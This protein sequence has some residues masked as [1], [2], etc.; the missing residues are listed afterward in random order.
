[1][2]RWL[3]SL[4]TTT[5]LGWVLAGAAFAGGGPGNQPPRPLEW[6]WKAD[7]ARELKKM[8]ATAI[9]E[10]EGSFYLETPH[11]RVRTWHTPL[12]TAQAALYMEKFFAVFS[13]AFLLKRGPA[14]PDYKP[15][16]CVHASRDDYLKASKGPEWSA[17]VC[18]P[19]TN[20]DGSPNI[21][22]HVY[23][24]PPAG[25]GR[26]EA[27]FNASVPL[28]VIQHEG[29][30]CL[31]HRLFGARP[32][33]YW[34]DEGAANY[35]GAWCLRWRQSE[36]GETWNDS[37]HRADRMLFSLWP[38][39]LRSYYQNH[40]EAPL[41]R[42]RE[43]SAANSMKE[44]YVDGGGELTRLNYAL[45]ESFI[46]F[47]MTSKKR[48]P[49]FLQILERVRALP[50]DQ[51]ESP[52]PLVTDEEARAHEEQW[53]LFLINHWGVK[54]ADAPIKARAAELRRKK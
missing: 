5:A 44:F 48:R 24:A 6:Q 53:L 21:S 28:S 3:F 15:L 4:L 14:Y 22:L 25:D 47:L 32:L 11:W 8:A 13:K 16:F 46:D 54:F 20:P 41:P 38:P 2:R 30:H 18:L 12:F 27:V 36:S 52:A 31:L 42:L 49:F 7:E 23:Y 34:L 1:M 37:V 43:L 19:G 26:K 9:A 35:Y 40:P 10:P 50:E 51:R 33:P 29:T 45:A 39:F 17:G